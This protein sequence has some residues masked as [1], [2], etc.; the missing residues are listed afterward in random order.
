LEVKLG[1]LWFR[2]RLDKK[3][4]R[5]PFHPGHGGVCLLSL[6]TQG[7]KKRRVTVQDR[8]GIEPDPMSKITNIEK[9]GGVVDVEYL[10]S[11]S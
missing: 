2:A 6:D 11:K 7:G 8:L 5:F 9:T 3:F 1:G 10:P 4:V